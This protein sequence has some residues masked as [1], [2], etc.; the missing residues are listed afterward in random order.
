[1]KK[2]KYTIPRV[3]LSTIGSVL[4]AMIFCGIITFSIG[5]I[6]K[7]TLWKIVMQLLNLLIFVPIVYS[8]SWYCG[9]RDSN[10]AAFGHGQIDPL[11]GLKIGLCAMIPFALMPVVLVLIKLTILPGDVGVLAGSIFRI[12]N[13]HML[14]TINALLEPGIPP[15]QMSWLSIVAIWLLPLVIPAIT[16]FAYYLGVKHISISDKIIFVKKDQKKKH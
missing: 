14:F 6:F 10:S 1:M 15:E 12:L 16:S 5:M 9:D 8:P 13:I 3:A 4:I 2:Q 7:S 11:K